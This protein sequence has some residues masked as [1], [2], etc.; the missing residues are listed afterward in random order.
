MTET[1]SF[2]RFQRV[3]LG[4]DGT[5][6]HILEAYA[7][8]PIE[9]LKLRQDFDTAGVDGGLL[10]LPADGRVLRRRVV[11]RGRRS[12]RHLLYAEAVV[13]PDRVAPT[14]LDGLVRT[15]APIGTLLAEN[16]TET[17]REILRVDK[18]PAGASGRH[19]GVDAATPVIFRTYRIVAQARPIMMITEKFPTD[20][21]LGLPA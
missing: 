4:T 6:T 10:D 15:E 7:G 11:L 2:T 13:V 19:L 16:R 14:V 8:E 1:A 21:F 3:L 9:V 12:K 5:V 17:F 20:S 18:E